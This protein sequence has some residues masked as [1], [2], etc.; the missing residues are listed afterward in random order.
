MRWWWQP[1]CLLRQVLINLKS[2]DTIQA[3]LWSTH[4]PWLTF[5]NAVALKAAQPP[6]PIDGEVVIHRDNVNFF[7]VLP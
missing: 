3:V 6:T 7:Q 2:D 1:P 4:G 5:R